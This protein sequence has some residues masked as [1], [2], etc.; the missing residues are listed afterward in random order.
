MGDEM[1]QASSKNPLNRLRNFETTVRKEMAVAKAWEKSWGFMKADAQDTVSTHTASIKSL[2]SDLKFLLWASHHVI[3]ESTL[4][5]EASH[6]V[7]AYSSVLTPSKGSW[8]V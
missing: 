1:D 8:Q 4:S 7:S 6:A 5:D 2:A 3:T